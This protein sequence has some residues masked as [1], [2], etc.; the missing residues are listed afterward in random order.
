MELTEIEA[1]LGHHLE[2][3]RYWAV[4]ADALEMDQ[5]L[6]RATAI[7]RALKGPLCEPGPEPGLPVSVQWRFGHWL[8]ARVPVDA[9]E[10]ALS[11][12]AARF[13]QHLVVEEK[14]KRWG[15]ALDRSPPTLSRLELRLR[16]SS[17]FEGLERLLGQLEVLCCLTLC[18]PQLPPAPELV[19]LAVGELGGPP[20]QL[21]PRLQVLELARPAGLERWPVSLL[22]SLHT[23]RLRKPTSLKVLVE[24]LG[25]PLGRQLRR[26]EVSGSWA[27]AQALQLSPA[28]WEHLERLVIDTDEQ[29]AGGE[30]PRMRVRQRVRPERYGPEPVFYLGLAPPATPLQLARALQGAAEALELQLERV[31]EGAWISVPEQVA[32]PLARWMAAHEGLSAQVLQV[33]S[34]VLGARLDLDVQAREITPDGFERPLELDLTRASLYYDSEQEDGDDST[35]YEEDLFDVAGELFAELFAYTSTADALFWVSA[36]WRPDPYALFRASASP[37]QLLA[38]A[39]ALPLDPELGAYLAFRARAGGAL[40][41][42]P[43]PELGRWVERLLRR[44]RLEREPEDPQA[45]YWADWERLTR[46]D[47]LLGAGPGTVPHY[48]LLAPGRW[49]LG[50]EEVETLLRALRRSVD[51][52]CCPPELEPRYRQAIE[53]MSGSRGELEVRVEP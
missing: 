47:R 15:L 13:L 46:S 21:V 14:G 39:R 38:G 50:P 8:A 25:S 31:G 22:P 35:R 48:K 3:P 24:L 52:H 53:W 20:E 32:L 40:E 11:L 49:L 5:Q 29:G 33:T 4:Y 28:L 18:A 6:E 16:G 26:L 23:L 9:L 27:L 10:A 37:R 42:A 45:P 7:R 36:S 12:P 30:S 1:A 43:V 51:H 17:G 41:L 44:H 2:D 19:E 34:L